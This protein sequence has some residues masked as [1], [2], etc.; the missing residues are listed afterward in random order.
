VKI[1]VNKKDLR[2]FGGDVFFDNK[3]VDERVLSLE[4]NK[5]ATKFR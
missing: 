2:F 5:T 1:L 4:F 3:I